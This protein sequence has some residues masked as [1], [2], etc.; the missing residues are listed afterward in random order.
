VTTTTA[1]ALNFAM[2]TPDPLRVTAGPQLKSAADEVTPMTGLTWRYF[3]LED[4]SIN[5][6]KPNT[7]VFQLNLTL[8]DFNKLNTPKGREGDAEGS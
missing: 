7:T 6:F 2:S 4:V 1:I 3:N 5:L 8:N